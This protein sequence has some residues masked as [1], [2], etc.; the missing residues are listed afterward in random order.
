M[1]YRGLKQSE[2]RVKFAAAVSALATVASA[3]SVGVTKLASLEV[4][5]EMV[6]NSSVKASITNTGIEDL[7]IFKTGSFLDKTPTEKVKILRANQMQSGLKESAF[8]IILVGET[9]ENKI[10]IAEL[11]DLSASSAFDIVSKGACHYAKIGSTE[12]SG[13]I[14]YSSDPIPTTID[15]LAASKVFK[16]FQANVKRQAEATVHAINACTDLTGQAASVAASGGDKLVEY[17]KNSNT[18]TRDYVVQVFNNIASECSSTS[19][20][21]LYHCTDVYKACS[22]GVIA[23]TLPSE[24]YIV[25]CPIFFSCLLAAGSECHALDQDGTVVHETSHFSSAAGI[26]DYGGYGYDFIQS[27]T[28]EQNLNHANTYAPF[29]QCKTLAL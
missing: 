25:N 6:G 28:A 21:A 14:T 8:Q 10:N 5:I 4:N 2:S 18:D 13:F 24:G 12:I 29:A 3:A 27:L 9:V 22:D 1:L 26:E 19:S 23:Y 17:I 16:D 7:K 20:G 15:G 11:H